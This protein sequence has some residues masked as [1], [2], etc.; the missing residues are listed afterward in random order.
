MDQRLQFQPILK[1]FLAAVFLT[2]VVL[3]VVAYSLLTT[4]QSQHPWADLFE[5]MKYVLPV[6]M[7]LNV[8]AAL[9]VRSREAKFGV[10][11][12]VALLCA[13]EISMML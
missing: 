8:G 2:F 6:L 5:N 3:V 11:L 4:G 9:L 12:C 10:S 13:I 1:L 7:A